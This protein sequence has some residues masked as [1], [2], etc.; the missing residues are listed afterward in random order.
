MRL[1]HPPN[2]AGVSILTKA[3]W[4]RYGIAAVFV[5]FYATSGQMWVTT[6]GQPYD[7]ALGEQK[8]VVREKAEELKE[9]AVSFEAGKQDRK[10]TELTI[11]YEALPSKV[12]PSAWS[13]AMIFFTVAS[14]ILFHLMCHWSIAF[15]VVFL[16]Q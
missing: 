10:E 13:C 16:Y 5:A 6:S 14:H 2:I 7:W 15:R 1:R 11:D 3:S 8:R 9:K 12:L 4:K